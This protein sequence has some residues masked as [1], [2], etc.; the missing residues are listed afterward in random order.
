MIFQ[1]SKSP[2]EI[3]SHC[4]RGLSFTRLGL[5]SVGMESETAATLSRSLYCS[6]RSL[7]WVL[8]VMG[9]IQMFWTL[10]TEEFLLSGSW[11]PYNLL[12]SCQVVSIYLWPKTW[13]QAPLSSTVSWSLLKF[14]PI[15][16]V[17]QSNHLILFHARLLL[18]SIFPSIRVFLNESV[19][20]IRWSK[21][22]SFS[23]Q[24]DFG[25]CT[26]H[27][28]PVNPLPTSQMCSKAGCLLVSFSPACSVMKASLQQRTP[29][30][31][32]LTWA[33]LHLNTKQWVFFPDCLLPATLFQQEHRA[34]IKMTK[35]QATDAKAL[36][37]D[38]DERS[39]PPR[40]LLRGLGTPAVRKG[41]ACFPSP[42]DL[43]CLVNRSGH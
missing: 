28:F 2:Q 17:M 10:S 11:I 41:R 27:V 31:S 3:V 39:S 8:D 33:P 12:F 24:L 42:Q 25:K 32:S 40:P 15:E 9:P 6:L 16:S 5:S 20:H 19:L 38:G 29:P 36:R 26:F 35:Y 13:S 34:A 43:N 1:N 18:P 23:L 21:L 30:A 14:M 4:G 7:A 37:T 22:W